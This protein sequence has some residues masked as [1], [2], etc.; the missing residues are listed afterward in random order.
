MVPALWPPVHSAGAGMIS[1]S[2]SLT[3]RCTRRDL[4]TC[5]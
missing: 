2:H 4:S 3:D 5:G 1:I